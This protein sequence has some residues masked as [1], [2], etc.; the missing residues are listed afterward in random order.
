MVKAN[1][2]DNTKKYFE[3]LELSEDASPADINRSYEK[4][5][6]IYS[7]ISIATHPLEEEFGE[8][9][10]QDILKE[11]EEAHQ[12]LLR[13][14]EEEDRAKKETVKAKGEKKDKL[15]D[16]AVEKDITDENLIKAKDIEI[17]N[18]E[19]NEVKEEKKEPPPAKP[20]VEEAKPVD[21]V[22]PAKSIEPVEPVEP[23]AVP[24][25]LLNKTVVKGRTLK[26]VREKLGIGIHEIA[27]STKISYKILV[28]IELER[29]E[30]L[31][32]AGYLRWHV[33]SYAKALSLDPKK[34][35][36]DYMKRYRRW[37]SKQE[38]SGQ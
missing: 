11:I 1:D 37:K 6:E 12:I 31:P 26:K 24:E 22:K 15:E 21:A 30:K 33:M 27:V 20:L 16:T 36:D 14:L 29:F 7:S 32:E 2:K 13:R 5:K 38:N 28:S 10:K 4:L 25:D 19:I 23:A 3:I 17:I 9:E 34:I 8:E 35:A 18:V